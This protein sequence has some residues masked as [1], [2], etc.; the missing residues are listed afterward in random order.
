MTGSDDI[1]TPAPFRISPL[2][3]VLVFAFL[4]SVNLGRWLCYSLA[5]GPVRICLDADFRCIRSSN[6]RHI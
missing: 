5:V 3:P 1:D 4:S 2:G 6:L